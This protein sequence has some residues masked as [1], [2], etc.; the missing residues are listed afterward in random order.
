[1]QFFTNFPLFLTIKCAET[2]K[3][4]KWTPPKK[5]KKNLKNVQEFNLCL[6]VIFNSKLLPSTCKIQTNLS[7]NWFLNIVY[8]NLGENTDHTLG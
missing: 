6:F 4:Q 7:C 2:L 3:T 1:M 8:G 5:K